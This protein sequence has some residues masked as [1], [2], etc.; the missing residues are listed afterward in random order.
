MVRIYWKTYGVL[1]LDQVHVYDVKY[2]LVVD[3]IADDA[4]CYKGCWVTVSSSCREITRSIEF[5]AA[6]CQDVG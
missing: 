1:R 4:G 5:K 6:E 3:N 2:I